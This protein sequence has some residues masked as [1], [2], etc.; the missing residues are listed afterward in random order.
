MNSDNVLDGWE[1]K[2]KQMEANRFF[3]VEPKSEWQNI[4]RSTIYSTNVTN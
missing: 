4:G 2:T 1:R 3:T